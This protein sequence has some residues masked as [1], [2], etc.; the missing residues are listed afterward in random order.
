[1]WQEA[2]NLSLTTRRYNCVSVT[3][4]CL[5]AGRE[6]EPTPLWRSESGGMCFCRHGTNFIALR[7]D[8]VED[9]DL[10]RSVGGTSLIGASNLSPVS[11][12]VAGTGAVSRRRP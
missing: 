6:G 11:N 8:R 2:S 4:P 5:P 7:C 1:M 12:L 10:L 9:P 3:R